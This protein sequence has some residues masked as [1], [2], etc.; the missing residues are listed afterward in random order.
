MQKVSVLILECKQKWKY[1]GRNNP[2]RLTNSCD[3]FMRNNE[4][5]T[6]IALIIEKSASVTLPLLAFYLMVL[7]VASL[8]PI[9]ASIT[10]FL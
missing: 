4:K 9:A 1:A 10:L 5:S 6:E 2:D 3:K 7:T 8:R